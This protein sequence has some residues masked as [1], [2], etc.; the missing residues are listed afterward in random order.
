MMK[1]TNPLSE[2]FFV[3]PSSKQTTDFCLKVLS[4]IQQND[5]RTDGMWNRYYYSYSRICSATIK[6]E[7]QAEAQNFQLGTHES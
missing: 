3:L 4:N 5:K 7:P 1:N 6:F 2:I